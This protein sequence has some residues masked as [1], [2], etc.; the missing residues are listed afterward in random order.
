MR[1]G[2]VTSG[3]THGSVT[4]ATSHMLNAWRRCGVLMWFPVVSSQDG[5]GSG[6]C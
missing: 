4:A 3:G 2:W 1:D 6:C 5:H